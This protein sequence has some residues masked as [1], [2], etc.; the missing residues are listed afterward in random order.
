[1]DDGAARIGSG[2]ERR[3]LDRLPVDQRGRGVGVAVDVERFAVDAD[4]EQQSL[5]ERDGEPAE[6]LTQLDGTTRRKI[7]VRDS[8][9]EASVPRFERSCR[10]DVAERVAG[11]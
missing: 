2:A 10:S 6:S 1:M 5:E 9:D 4:L 8:R 11:T 7:N 3:L